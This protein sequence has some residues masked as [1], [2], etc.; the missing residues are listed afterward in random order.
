MLE[1][2][3]EQDTGWVCDILTSCGSQILAEVRPSFLKRDAYGASK[4]S[5]TLGSLTVPS[6]GT[7]VA[8]TWKILT[9]A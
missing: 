6:S 3:E 9:V 1:A 4:A 5:D 2:K 8:L 7:R